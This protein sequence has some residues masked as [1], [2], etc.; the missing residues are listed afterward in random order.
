MPFLLW[1]TSKVPTHSLMSLFRAPASVSNVLCNKPPPNIKALKMILIRL[2][3]V[4]VV[5]LIWAGLDCSLTVHGQ[6]AWWLGSGYSRMTSTKMTQLCLIWS[7]LSLADEL[8]LVLIAQLWV[9]E[10][11]GKRANS[12]SFQEMLHYFCHILL[13]KVSHQTHPDSRGREIHA[14]ESHVKWHY[15]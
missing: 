3:V 10:C 8:G 12:W 11:K 14:P 13:A 9:Q 2:L 5:L 15:G 6:L 4:W 1:S 7:L